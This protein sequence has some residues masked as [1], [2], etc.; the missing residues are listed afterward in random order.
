M[1]IGTRAQ[2]WGKC[3]RD[4]KM[5]CAIRHTMRASWSSSWSEWSKST[6]RDPVQETTMLSP[7]MRF[8]V[9]GMRASRAQTLKGSK[10]WALS[11]L[12]SAA[13]ASPSCR[14]RRRAASSSSSSSSIII[15]ITSI[16]IIIIIII[17]VIVI[18]ITMPEHESCPSMK[19]NLVKMSNRQT[20]CAAM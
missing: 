5:H 6:P 12:A 16:I 10:R 9:P 20:T 19:H 14:R 7:G 11:K 4:F 18:I 1:A 17:I 3:D 8:L 2:T 13:S 15:I